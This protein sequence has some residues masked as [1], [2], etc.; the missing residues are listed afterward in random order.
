LIFGDLHLSQVEAT[1]E[2]FESY[3]NGLI[4]NDKFCFTRTVR[5]KLT[6]SRFP[7]RLRAQSSD[8]TYPPHEPTHCG[9]NNETS[10]ENLSPIYSGS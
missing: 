2:F 6:W 8:A 7:L 1:F 3:F 4:A 9:G 10:L 5:L